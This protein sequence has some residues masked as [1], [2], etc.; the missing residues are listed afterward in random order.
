MY[1]GVRA[2]GGIGDEIQDPAGDE[3]EFYRVVFDITFF[4]FVIVILLAII[5][6]ENREATWQLVLN[7][8]NPLTQNVQFYRVTTKYVSTVWEIREWN[9]RAMT[10]S[11]NPPIGWQ[12]WITANSLRRF[13]FF[14]F[15]S[16]LFFIF[17]FKFRQENTAKPLKLLPLKCVIISVE[18]F[19]WIFSK[20]QDFQNISCRYLLYVKLQN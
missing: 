16:F 13:F 20:K 15:F 14:F 18:L 4:F 3:S 6:G 9:L 17:F 10:L 5:Q 7:P 19:H 11:Q 8:V 1:V 2:G 12:H